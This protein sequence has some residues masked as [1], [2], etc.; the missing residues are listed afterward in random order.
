[1]AAIWIP[2][3]PFQREAN[4]DSYLRLN[5]LLVWWVDP[6]RGALF[7]VTAR[8]LVDANLSRQPATRNGFSRLISM[9]STTVDLRRVGS[10]VKCNSTSRPPT[11]TY[12]VVSTSNKKQRLQLRKTFLLSS[13]IQS[14]FDSPRLSPLI[15]NCLLPP[16]W[17]NRALELS[18]TPSVSRLSLVSTVVQ[19]ASNPSRTR[20]QSPIRNGCHSPQRDSC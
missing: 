20:R 17:P 16:D 3:T 14:S 4:H 6:G 1:M 9:L 7:G 2:C 10:P 11:R 15:P 12:W 18:L 8:L 13:L 5:K 19:R